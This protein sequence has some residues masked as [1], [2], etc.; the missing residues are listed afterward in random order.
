MIPAVLACLLA[1]SAPLPPAGA[2]PVVTCRGVAATIVGTPRDDVL[3]G[4]PGPDVIVGLGG[5]DVIDGRGGRDLLC[6]GE[7]NDVLRGGAGSDILDGGPGFDRLYGG[8]GRDVLLGGS[9]GDRLYGGRDADTLYGGPGDDRLFG[10]GGA[11][12]LY[13]GPGRDR[14]DGGP[15][16]DSCRTERRAACGVPVAPPCPAGVGCGR[17][18]APGVLDVPLVV[19]EP[20]GVARS[21]APVTSGIPIP[22]VVG[23]TDTARLRLLDA[24][25]RRVPAQFTPLARWGG[26][27][28]DPSAV[29][30]W[31]LVD[32]QADVPAG[33][34]AAFRLVN[35]GGPAPAAAP[36]EVRDLPGAVVVETGAARFSIS[37]ADGRLG[38]P[39][40]RAPVDALLTFG[41]GT[42]AGMRG[43][44]DV[45]VK[46]GG[47]MRAVVE[48]SG[49]LRTE[50]GRRILGYTA[51]YWFYAGRSEVRLFFTVENRTPCPLGADAQ[52]SCH[53]VGS[54]GSRSFADLSLVLPAAPGGNPRYLLG[55]QGRAL[56]GRLDGR[57]LLHQGSSGTGSWDHYATLADWDGSPLDARPRLQAYAA[58]RGYRATLGGVRI[59]AGDHAP[60]T[61]A[62]GG[63]TGWWGVQVADFWEQFPKSLR[64]R[65]DGTMEIGLFPGEYGPRGFAYVLRAGEQKTHE[66]WLR[67]GAEGAP[68]R[69]QALAATAP[70]AWYV[71]SGAVGR[72]A[73]PGAG[74]GEH[75]T[76]LAAQLDPGRRYR[77][78][79]GWYGDLPEAVEQT[80]FYGI[81]D[82]GDWPIDYEGYGV[83]PLN[84]KYDAG[85]GAWIQWMRSGDPRWRELAEAGNRHFAD[86]DVLHTLHR[87]RHWSDGIA[88]G[89]SYHDE[90]GFENPHRNYGGTHPDTAFGPKGLLL[91]YYLTGYEPARRAALEVADCIEHRLR[92][93]LHLCPYLSQCSGEG[94]A[95]EEGIHSN[96][97]RPAG[98]A[99]AIVVEAYRAT[100]ES[101]YL[102]V[103]DALVAWGAAEAQPYLSGPD[104]TDRFVKPWALGLY[105][106]ALADYLEVLGEFGLPDRAGARASYLAYAGWLVDHALIPLP[107][108]R[109]GPRAALPYEWWLDGR[110]ANAAP[111]VT[112][113][114][115][116]GAD[117]LA[118]AHHLGGSGRYLAAAAA[119]FRAG[120]HDPWFEGDANTYSST[121]E[122]ANSITW[123]NTFLWE[124]AATRG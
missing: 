8:P 9:G 121:K 10:G 84:L 31:L 92:N 12:R 54:A 49:W 108:L 76:Y 47:P 45:A 95:L 111:D 109:S 74:W 69:G 41:D 15:G 34:R 65:R 21:A 107:P 43:P 73:L 64:A 113:W 16:L 39:G 77:P 98:N 83:A 33:G 59:G 97:E 104:G 19:A 80:D 63:D 56:T 120:S 44:V 25:G 29:I 1:G 6:G 50:D 58:R 55:G 22:R 66:V 70:A 71:G 61:L 36:L 24:S 117:V 88:F 28:D 93:D 4:T 82:Y 102:E 11:D 122:T 17:P 75:E 32:F 85:W 51:Q 18:A 3:I 23:L 48:V 40:L 124:W 53:A 115:L 89:H 79:M 103:A 42:T 7:G 110:A 13:G 90:T 81:F 87:P 106:R 105:L 27:P 30:R 60:G 114:L 2:S 112:N 101:R 99:L 38:G 68:P 67:R 72:T 52:I 46:A 35:A 62:V 37:R 57:L 14:G 123:G 119:L 86:A 20:S 116:L 94:W 118:Y 100:G 91:T 5:N 26:G 96:G 78:W